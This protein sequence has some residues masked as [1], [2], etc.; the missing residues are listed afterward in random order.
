MRLRSQ[1][2]IISL[3]YPLP[4]VRGDAPRLTQVFVNLL[5]NANKFAPA[6]STI[7]LGGMEDEGPGL[8]QGAGAALFARFERFARATG[9]EPEQSG[10]GLGLWIAKSIIERHGGQIAAERQGT[11]TR[12]CVTLPVSQAIEVVEM[13]EVVEAEERVA[14]KILVV[15]DDLEL[16]GLVGFALR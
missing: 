16:L 8:P 1:E 12:L 10:M 9:E 3:P 14:M 13:V 2:A 5:A 15:D 7:S 6:G 11:G 4:L